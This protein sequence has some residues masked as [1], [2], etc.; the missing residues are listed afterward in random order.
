MIHIHTNEQILN[1][2]FNF[3][4]CNSFNLEIMCSIL[5]LFFAFALTLF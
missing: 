3:S 1:N 5:E 4:E 2:D